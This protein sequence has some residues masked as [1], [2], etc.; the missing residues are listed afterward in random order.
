MS[1]FLRMN[2]S[3][4]PSLFLS[5][6]L[7]LPL[8]LYLNIRLFLPSSGPWTA[9]IGEYASAWVKVGKEGDPY[10]PNLQLYLS[11]AAFSMDLGLFLPY[12]YNYDQQ[13]SSL[14]SF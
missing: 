3:E 4:S 13:V 5:L 7:H 12:I 9:P 1:L 8:Y 14:R 10:Y 6:C 2:Y 11:P